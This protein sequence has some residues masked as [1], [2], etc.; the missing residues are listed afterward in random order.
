[1]LI[2]NATQLLALFKRGHDQLVQTI[3]EVQ[4]V[5][6]DYAQAKPK[7]QDLYRVLLEHVSRQDQDFY[8]HLQQS[9][10]G[11]R[12]TV[13]LLEFLVHD[14]KELRIAYLT[15]MDKHTAELA[16]QHPQN[17]PKDFSNFSQQILTRIKV[18]EE[19][20][21]PLLEKINSAAGS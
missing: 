6:R 1:M 8:N 2:M 13:K 15:F 19:Y 16:D 20:L 9:W 18:E 10:G 21:F 11:D 14:L 3:C 5:Q 7:I 17:F 12:P 4:L